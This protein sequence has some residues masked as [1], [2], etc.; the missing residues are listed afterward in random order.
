MGK[1]KFLMYINSEVLKKLKIQA[2]EEEVP[3]STLLEKII[4]EY[5]QKVGK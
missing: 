4:I 5:L 2:V 1:S 3:I